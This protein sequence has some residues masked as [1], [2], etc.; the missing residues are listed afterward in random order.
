MPESPNSVEETAATWPSMFSQPTS[1]PTSGIVSG[2]AQQID[3]RST[4]NWAVPLR[5]EL[6]GRSIPVTGLYEREWGLGL[7]REKCTGHHK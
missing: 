7:Q 1:Q 4:Y 2:C 3:Q 6:R 5:H